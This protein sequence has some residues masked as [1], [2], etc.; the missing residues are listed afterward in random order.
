MNVNHAAIHIENLRKDYGDVVAVRDLCLDVA[1][2]EIFCYLGPNG[3]GKT[4]TIKILAG[5]L[6]PTAGLARIMGYDIQNEPVA[7]KRL[8]GYIPD[9]P[10]LYEKLTGRDFFYFIADLFGIDRRMAEKR[11]KEYFQLFGL[12]GDED[13]FIE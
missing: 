10:Y 6:R 11:L 7:A 1:P 9:H 8:I 4:T 3:A 12:K 13:T 2:G 5:L